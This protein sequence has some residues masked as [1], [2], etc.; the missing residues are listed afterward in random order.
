MD[1]HRVYLKQK[2][3]FMKYLNKLILYDIHKA[4]NTVPN[5]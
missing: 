4:L 1:G 5:T 2:K 3:K